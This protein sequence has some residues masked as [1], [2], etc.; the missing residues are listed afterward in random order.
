[1]KRQPV[2]IDCD[3]G[4]DDALNLLLAFSAQDQLNILGITTVAG[5][6]SVELPTF[7]TD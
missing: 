1:M 3:P 6:A 5:N 4:A 7:Y 2:I